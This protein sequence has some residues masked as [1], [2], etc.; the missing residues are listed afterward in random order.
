VKANGGVN[1]RPAA[2]S[3]S[4][5]AMESET[6]P[7]R[8]TLISHAPTAALKQASFPLDEVLSEDQIQKI[9]NLRWTAPR[10]QH[11]Y[12]GPEKRTQQTAKALGLEPSAAVELADVDYGMWNG[13]DI[14]EVYATDPDG[15]T[16]WLTDVNASPHGGES[17]TRLIARVQRWMEGRIAGHTVAVTHSVVVRAAVVCAL[18]AAPESFSR[19]E[20]APLTLTDLRFNGKHWTLRSMGCPLRTT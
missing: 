12:C 2:S 14:E 13:K 8:I 5:L 20:I 10:A 16:C 19:V 6:L 15:L 1:M 3:C 11:I 4:R 9:L 17:F 7:I 18:Q